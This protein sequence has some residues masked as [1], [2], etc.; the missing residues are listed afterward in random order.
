MQSW[1][2]DRL[3]LRGWWSNAMWHLEILSLLLKRTV[4]KLQI[5][6]AGFEFI[7]TWVIFASNCYKSYGNVH[8]DFSISRKFEESLLEDVWAV[9]PTSFTAP[10]RG[11]HERRGSQSF[12]YR[13]SKSQTGGHQCSTPPSSRAIWGQVLE[14]SQVNLTIVSVDANLDSAVAVDRTGSDLIIDLP[15][16]W[17]NSWSQALRVCDWGD[18]W[19]SV[20]LSQWFD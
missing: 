19:R 20:I 18:V 13:Q 6:G 4:G 16:V 2:M 15:G 3:Y 10:L 5:F 9:I 12:S 1:H 7:S 14:H 8:N 17:L 11:S